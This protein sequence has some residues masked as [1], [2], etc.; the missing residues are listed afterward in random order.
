MMVR[1]A[2]MLELVSLSRKSKINADALLR[3]SQVTVEKKDME[4]GESDWSE[5]FDEYFGGP[6]DMIQPRKVIRLI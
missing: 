2:R 6:D 5:K 3:L 1:M 4:S